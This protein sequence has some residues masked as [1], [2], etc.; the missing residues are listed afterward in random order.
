MALGAPPGDGHGRVLVALGLSAGPLIGLGLARFAYAMLLPSMRA[1]LGWSYTAAGAMNTANAAGYL[2]GAVVAAQLA[3]RFGSRRLFL[4]GT[5]L[6]TVAIALTAASEVYAVLLAVRLIAG[7]GGGLAFVVGGGLVAE[8]SHRATRGRAALMLGLYYGGVGPGIVLAGILVPWVLDL[9]GGTGWRQGWLVLGAISLVGTLVAVV[10]ARRVA[11]PAPPDAQAA[12]WDRGS[13]G[14]LV[15]AYTAFGMG[16]ICYLTFMTAFLDEAGM[17]APAI[18]GFWV[19]VGLAAWLSPAW[20]PVYGRIGGGRG[21]ALVMTVLAVGTVLPVFVAGTATAYLS[22]VL[23]GGT[24][25]ACVTAMSVGVREA[26]PQPHWTAGLGF[27]TVAFGLAQTVGPSL[28]GWVSDRTHDLGSGLLVS[29]VI[30][31][32]GIVLA[33]VHHRRANHLLDRSLAPHRRP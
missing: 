30:L 17:S 1:D 14:W 15:A 29:G 9:T 8:A 3:R 32:L 33:L 18:T 12:R 27:A 6:T 11:D 22:G 31:V 19:V 13:I 10:S 16:Y 25:L 20:G 7:V 28:T 24:F 21:L 5:W 4:W 2:L 26:L 23:V